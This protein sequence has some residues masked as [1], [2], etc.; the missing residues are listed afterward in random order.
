MKFPCEYFL[1][2][3]LVMQGSEGVA[4]YIQKYGYPEPSAEYLAKLH[5]E[6]QKNRPVPFIPRSR[7]V[8]SWRRRL[9][10]S[11]AAIRSPLMVK[12]ERW[13]RST[14][15]RTALEML[16]IA[17]L[18]PEQ[19]ANNMT[20]LA[21][22]TFEVEAVQLYAHYFW[23]RSVL[24]YGE[25]QIFLEHYPNGRELRYLYTVDP[26]VALWKTGVIPDVDDSVALDRLQG[27]TY[28]RMQELNTHPN[29]LKTAMTHSYWAGTY[30]KTKEE[31]RQGA[32]ALTKILHHMHE[33]SLL[34]R[35]GKIPD[36]TPILDEAQILQI[37]ERVE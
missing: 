35:S 2:H 24:T 25:W 29:T 33:M 13:T 7:K 6:V 28:M 4:E 12:A 10:I 5:A 11:S 31:K 36:G 21:G 20:L 1:K 22:V 9:K 23:N 34:L 15:I 27:D 14:I 8:R 17:G 32:H 30:F 19:V 18:P 37:P 3:L 16:L 26:A